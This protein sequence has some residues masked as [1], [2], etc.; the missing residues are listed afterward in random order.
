MNYWLDLFTGTTW[1]EFRGA[2][3]N[4]SGFRPIRRKTVERIKPGD[5]LLCYLTGVMRW[6]GA[7]EVISQSNDTRRIWNYDEFPAR[8]DVKPLILL[9][10]EYGLQMQKLEGK[11]HFY[12]GSNDAGKF[13]GFLRG[14]PARFESQAD[15]DLILNMLKEAKANPVSIP[16]DLHKL[17]RK[18][19]FK[20]K[21][22]VGDKKIETLVSVPGAEEATEDA[23]CIA[24]SETEL[25]P[26]GTDHTQIQY[27]LLTLGAE[28]GLDVWVA[29]NDKSKVWQ[30]KSLGSLPGIVE[31]LPT[32][33]NEATQRTIELIDVLWLKGNS[34]V[35]AFEVEC[36]TSIYSGL[37]RMSDLLA[38]QPNLDIK[39]Y[40]VAPDE[41]HDKVEQEILRPTF[42]LRPK[43]LNKVCGF[44]ALNDLMKKVE[45]IREL[46]LAS[47]LN[48]DFLVDTAEY[49]GSN[50]G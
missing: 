41:R 17:E 25:V 26:T 23:E 38:L 18:P 37:L 32:Q 43:P 47:S 39:L 42:Q 12:E 19:F 29:R 6:V 27:L 50:D 21:S 4:V 30:G 46:G 11:V 8:L 45:G 9:D 3:A 36:T 14:S 2:G 31:Q 44:L 48:P 40:L 28:M 33:F 24:A 34:I 13:K 5:I 1:R 16:V 35:S 15:G 20:T 10:P 7:L 49:F 22:K